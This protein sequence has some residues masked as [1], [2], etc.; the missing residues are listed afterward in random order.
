MQ[1]NLRFK[2]GM[3]CPIM[4]TGM[5][6]EARLAIPETD[7]E[8]EEGSELFREA[9]YQD[10][11]RQQQVQATMSEWHVDEN[12]ENQAKD[13]ENIIGKLLVSASPAVVTRVQRIG[14]AALQTFLS[15]NWLGDKL[16]VDLAHLLPLYFYNSPIFWVG[17]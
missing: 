2:D 17:H 8:D 1:G 14:V 15:V 6:L 12:S 9:R 11:L 5:D 4:S 16:G 3:R 10:Y 7:C 13:L